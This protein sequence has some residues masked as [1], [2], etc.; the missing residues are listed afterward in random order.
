[1]YSVK[2]QLQK[3]QFIRDALVEHRASRYK[4]DVLKFPYALL[5]MSY[6]S[7]VCQYDPARPLPHEGLDSGQCESVV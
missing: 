1:M 5:L 2:Y 4:N 6:T 7:P 3:L